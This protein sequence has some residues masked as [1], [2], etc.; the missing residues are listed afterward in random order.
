MYREEKP[1]PFISLYIYA[2]CYYLLYTVG[3]LARLNFRLSHDINWQTD[4]LM[5]NKTFYMFFVYRAEGKYI[6]ARKHIKTVLE[7]YGWPQNRSSHTT[8]LPR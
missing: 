6:A 1:T 4:A 5:H 7:L 8:T 2:Y 3:M